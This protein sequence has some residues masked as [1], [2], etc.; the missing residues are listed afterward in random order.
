MYAFPVK[1][2]AGVFTVLVTF[3]PDFLYYICFC[4]TREVPQD[5]IG[6][7]VA[8]VKYFSLM[9]L[10]QFV[11]MI[12]DIFSIVLLP[13]FLIEWLTSTPRIG[14]MREKK[15]P[16]KIYGKPWK[17]PGHH[18]RKNFMWR[19]SKECWL[20]LFLLYIVFVWCT[21][22]EQVPAVYTQNYAVEA[23]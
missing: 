13:V 19:Y 20:L 5:E 21:Y 3:Y 17:N 7:D 14:Y 12:L 4:E 23:I 9:L 1:R 18:W 6:K 11:Q 15:L 22:A 10:C 2:I 16:K 8:A